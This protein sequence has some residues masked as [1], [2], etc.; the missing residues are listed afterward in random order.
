MEIVKKYKLPY[1]NG[2]HLEGQI[3]AITEEGFDKPNWFCIRVVYP[4]SERR[5]SDIEIGGNLNNYRELKM[6]AENFENA[7]SMLRNWCV[8]ESFKFSEIDLN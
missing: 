5:K 4:K 7:D 1:D 8:E 3:E 6:G 2:L